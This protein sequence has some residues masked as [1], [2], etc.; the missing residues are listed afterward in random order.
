MERAEIGYCTLKFASYFSSEVAFILPLCNKPSKV[1]KNDRSREILGIEY[2]RSEKEL[3]LETCESMMKMGIIPTRR[4]WLIIRRSKF[5]IIKN[6]WKEHKIC[7]S[8]QL[9]WTNSSKAKSQLKLWTSAQRLVSSHYRKTS[10]SPLKSAAWPTVSL[11]Q[12]SSTTT[13]KK[14]ST[15][16]WETCSNWNSDWTWAQSH[17]LPF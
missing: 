7:Q 3:L 16:Y 4:A 14:S 11:R 8:Y 2:K 5:V 17:Y 15:M 6:K 12:L 1:F 9:K 13:S 10:C